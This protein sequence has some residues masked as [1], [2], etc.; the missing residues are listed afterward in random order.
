MDK[1]AIEHAVG[2][3]ATDPRERRGTRG[4]TASRAR[5]RSRVTGA[6]P[7]PRGRVL[8]AAVPRSRVA[9]GPGV[10]ADPRFVLELLREQTRVGAR[11][12]VLA[13]L[14]GRS[15]H[16]DQALISMSARSDGPAVVERGAAAFARALDLAERVRDRRAARPVRGRA[17]DGAA[18][19]A[20]EDA[21]RAAWSAGRA[22]AERWAEACAERAA[23][24]LG[25][26][27]RALAVHYA[28][29]I[30]AAGPRARPA[31]QQRYELERGALLEGT[32]IRVELV[33]LAE[34]AL[35]APE[36]VCELA[37]RG[38]GHS[39]EIWSR[40][41][42]AT[43]DVDATAC[44]ACGG[45]A[46]TAALCE[47]GGHVACGACARAC[48]SCARVAC[49]RCASDAC[50]AC[51]RPLCAACARSCARCGRPVC[52]DDALRCAACEVLA[53]V[54]CGVRSC[55]GCGAACC[56]DHA[57]T[58]ARCPRRCCTGCV[59]SCAG[60]AAGVCRADAGDCAHCGQRHC[61]ACLA[62]CA[63][64]EA[65]LCAHDLA[66]HRARA[67]APGRIP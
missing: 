52:A 63:A 10:R 38:R 64:C 50:C 32:R 15:V 59:S 34:V 31:L 14:R 35:V 13:A 26:E 65:V 45:P 40:V 8:V 33:G 3:E 67:H 28:R 21:R 43:G 55:A 19:P 17:V 66:A 18:T 30:A 44:A 2:P 9:P 58:C 12:V 57:R 46:H 22:W 54:D 41:D 6:D 47:P 20:L 48:G 60:C 51:G 49:V 25:S 36:R 27:L 42:L 29:T 56:A 7:S 5:A 24:T 4:G 53:C 16:G 61:A 62:T 37:L 39:V 1:G 11:L 23:A